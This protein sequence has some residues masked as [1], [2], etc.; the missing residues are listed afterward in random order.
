MST[1][2]YWQRPTSLC[3]ASTHSFATCAFLTCAPLLLQ[4]LQMISSVLLSFPFNLLLLSHTSPLSPVISYLPSSPPKTHKSIFTFSYHFFTSRC[5]TWFLVL[6]FSAFT[7]FLSFITSLLIFYCL[8]FFSL[9]KPWRITFSTFIWYFFPDHLCTSF[10]P[11]LPWEVFFGTW[12]LWSFSPPTYLAST[13]FSSFSNKHTEYSTIVIWGISMSYLT[14]L[15][16]L[17]RPGSNVRLSK[18]LKCITH[19]QKIA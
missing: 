18:F 7:R 16:P 9:Q 8:T 12:T 19:L 15:F 17:S 13:V 3:S 2:Y 4:S 14:V 5:Q 1:G 10:L 6:C 11:S